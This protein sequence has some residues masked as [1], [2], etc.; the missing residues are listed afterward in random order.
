MEVN[1]QTDW[2]FSPHVFLPDPSS[3]LFWSPF[4]PPP[5]DEES[6]DE[7]EF[8]D[9]FN[10][11]EITI[12]KDL[13]FKMEIDSNQSISGQVSSLSGSGIQVGDQILEVNYG[14]IRKQIVCEDDIKDIVSKIEKLAENQQEFDECNLIV[15][16]L[17][18]NHDHDMC[19]QRKKSSHV[20][21]LNPINSNLIGGLIKEQDSMDSY[22][23]NEMKE[24]EKECQG[25][26]KDLESITCQ[27]EKKGKLS[28]MNEEEDSNESEEGSRKEFMQMKERHSREKTDTKCNYT[29]I[30]DGKKEKTR[31]VFHQEGEIRE[32]EKREHSAR[33][34]KEYLREEAK[35]MKPSKGSDSSADNLNSSKPDWNRDKCDDQ[36]LDKNSISQTDNPNG[37]ICIVNTLLDSSSGL[38]KLRDSLRFKHS[39][40]KKRDELGSVAQLDTSIHTSNTSD[41][42]SKVIPI[43]HPKCSKKGGDTSLPKYDPKD[44]KESIKNWIKSSLENSLKLRK[45]KWSSKACSS[46]VAICQPNPRPLCPITT[47]IRLTNDQSTQ[48]SNSSSDSCISKPTSSR[49]YE[50]IDPIINKVVLDRS[51]IENGVRRLPDPLS[52]PV[53]RIQK[54]LLA[55]I[56][57]W[58]STM[59]TN[60]ANLQHTIYLQQQLLKLSLGEKGKS[61]EPTFS[62]EKAHEKAAHELPTTKEWPP[63]EEASK[64]RRK[65]SLRKSSS[66]Q[67]K[68]NSVPNARIPSSNSAQLF[69]PKHPGVTYLPDEDDH[70]YDEV[71]P[72]DG[73]KSFVP[74]VATDCIKS[75]INCG[76]EQ[77]D[78]GRWK[79]KRRPDGT[80]YVT[81]DEVRPKLM[82]EAR[83]VVA[84]RDAS[85]LDRVRHR[86]LTSLE[87]KRMSMVRE[88]GQDNEG[89]NGELLTVATV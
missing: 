69:D 61:V 45:E 72:E 6:H 37:C 84:N 55:P 18:P 25:F 80:R 85:L 11:F 12:S 76:R 77:V 73:H 24:L 65:S 43:I 10:Y 13:L 86:Q 23:V 58:P 19:L 89:K 41:P 52:S 38:E 46:K 59:Y 47:H 50:E 26:M 60:R 87:K 30:R 64:R 3:L 5:P 28:N 17:N 53:T 9:A 82:S 74:K 7:D 79:V 22:L 15:A 40:R 63:L 57:E 27:E 29:G 67:Y 36:V 48:M 20:H 14:S 81:R 51:A 33:E 68:R 66:F 8:C 35:G 88:E 78:H 49:I 16:R 21:L 34:A 62:N 1:T 75:S 32:G 39:L 2:S 71:S 56:N 83:K 4:P 31:K 44:K 42:R 70:I 54:S